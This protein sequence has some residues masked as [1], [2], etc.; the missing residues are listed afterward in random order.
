MSSKETET[1][2]GSGSDLSELKTIL[3]EKQR[4]EIDKKIAEAE[5]SANLITP[6]KI[7]K[8]LPG[9]IDL[10]LKE[11][12]HEIGGKLK[13]TIEFAM[14]E[15]VRENPA[16]ITNIIYPIIGP[17]IRKSVSEAFRKMMQNTNRI[18]EEAMSLKGLKW[19]LEAALTGKSYSQI[20][21][22]NS[23]VYRVEH[24][25]LIHKETGLLINH[26]VNPS[27]SKESVSDSDMVSSMFSAIQDFARDAFQ[28]NNQ[29]GI[30]TLAVGDTTVWVERG[31]HA[32]LAAV[33]R[34]EAP[35]DLREKMQLLLETLHKEQNNALRSFQ[36]DLDSDE[37]SNLEETLKNCFDEKYTTVS[38][39]AEVEKKNKQRVIQYCLLALFIGVLGFWFLNQIQSA[40][41]SRQLDAKLTAFENLLYEQ[42]GIAVSQANIQ[43]KPTVL[44]VIGL[45]DPLAIDVE[46]LA[47]KEGVLDNV[48]IKLDSF[49]SA[50]MEIVRQRFIL[51]TNPPPNLKVGIAGKGKLRLSGSAPSAWK[52]KAKDAV[53]G[54]PGLMSIEMDGVRGPPPTTFMALNKK[55]EAREVFFEDKP[56]D[57]SSVQKKTMNEAASLINQLVSVASKD[58]AHKIQAIYNANQTTP[59]KM[60]R[61]VSAVIQTVKR[62][63]S[64]S[65]FD[66]LKIEPILLPVR[67]GGPSVRFK[68][69]Q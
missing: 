43:R 18:A 67:G 17:A 48:S 32:F 7:A 8:A 42:P 24:L 45:K 28:E 34:G 53:T 68:F 41:A 58:S 22:L 62:N 15:S 1:N 56:G 50:D 11:N 60:K 38:N 65:Q 31:P 61:F 59:L 14:E 25:F 49:L 9:A 36:G 35:A 5:E 23:L 44:K 64:S 16:I 47:K 29:A 57:F 13:P 66:E 55:L 33:I 27:V 10:N 20:V 30:R 39:E 12:P 63:A 54:T 40:K 4:S 52:K 19:R 26:L 3:F 46:E 51:K 6:E 21:L 69:T 37:N 2:N